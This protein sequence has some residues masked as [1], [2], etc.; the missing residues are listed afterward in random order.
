MSWLVGAL[1]LAWVGLIAAVATVNRPGPRPPLA[2]RV[3]LARVSPVAALGGWLRAGAGRP[4]DPIADRRSGRMVVGGAAGA[5]V[6]LRLG[7]VLVIAALIAPVLAHRR[8]RRR[9]DLAVVRELPQVID[10]LRL[11]L[12][13]GGS[14]LN[15]IEIVGRHPIGPVSAAFAGVRS[16]IERGR[17]LAEALTAAAAGLGEPVRPLFRTLV[18]SEHYGTEVGTAL[19]RLADE[20]RDQLRR[21]AQAEARRVPVRLLLPLVLAILPAFVLLTIVPTLAGTFAGLD[22]TEP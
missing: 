10:L 15:A 11:G 12:A 20:A 14:V 6:D 18:G 17:R 7:A 3:T 16:E 2:R 5:V 22:L 9:R 4:A 8:D 1:A 19:A 13:A 21:R